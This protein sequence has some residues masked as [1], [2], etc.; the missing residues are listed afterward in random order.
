MSEADRDIESLENG[1]TIKPN[2]AANLAYMQRFVDWL[3]DHEEDMDDKTFQR[4]IMYMD[5]LGKNVGINIAREVQQHFIQSLNA[6]QPGATVPPNMGAVAAPPQPAQ[7]GAP[8]S[9]PPLAAP[10]NAPLQ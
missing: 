3:T 4:F 5:S 7:P 9:L 8:V 10:T 6:I 2:P 1:E